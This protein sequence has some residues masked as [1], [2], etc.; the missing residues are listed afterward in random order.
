MIEVFLKGFCVGFFIAMPVG[1]IGL[2][3]IQHSLTRFLSGFVVGL[4]AALA[5]GV[6]G[7]ILALGLS[8][9]STFLVAG[10][11]WL[12][13]LGGLFLCGLGGH[14]YFSH[15]SQKKN[16]IQQI[17]PFHLLTSTFFL[18][19][20][21][22][23]TLFAFVGIYIGVGAT[24]S[25]FAI[26]ENLFLVLGVVLGSLAWWFI[27]SFSISFLKKKISL[28]KIVFFQH[29]AGLGIIAFGLYLLIR[30]IFG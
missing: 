12:Q 6:Y 15:D 19:L 8:A 18:T 20:T 26:Y 7:V 27:L 2:L 14:I 1:P 10:K 24:L 5:D 22:P 29:I 25:S 30:G 4:G 16:E 17:K 11:V 3:C 13:I 28:K 23:M 21:N 9:V